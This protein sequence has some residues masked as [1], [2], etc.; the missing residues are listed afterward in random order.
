MELTLRPKRVTSIR[1]WKLFERMI[2]SPFFMSIKGSSGFIFDFMCLWYPSCVLLDCTKFVSIFLLLKTIYVSKLAIKDLGSLLAIL[3]V[4]DSLDYTDDASDSPSSFSAF[5]ST[6]S[7]PLREKTTTRW[8]NSFSMPGVWLL[9][10]F[11]ISF[12]KSTRFK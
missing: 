3:A 11:S 2:L 5:K 6:M 9:I 12:F 10:L 1:S 8:M 7:V 4:Q